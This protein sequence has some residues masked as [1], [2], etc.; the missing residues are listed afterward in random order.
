MVVVAVAGVAK[1]KVY[2]DG[3]MML[4]NTLIFVT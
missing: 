3:R 4:M 2:D 1:Q